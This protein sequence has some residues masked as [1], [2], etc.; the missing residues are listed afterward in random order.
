MVMILLQLELKYKLNEVIYTN[1]YL[2][3]YYIIFNCSLG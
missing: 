1:Y 3:I 2:E